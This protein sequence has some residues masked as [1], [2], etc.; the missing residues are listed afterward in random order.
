MSITKYNDIVKDICCVTF[1][2][3]QG[4]NMQAERRGQRPDHDLL[5]EM[6]G[7]IGVSC[8]LAFLQGISPTTNDMLAHFDMASYHFEMIDRPLKRL[9][10]NGV[11]A[12]A[13]DLRND[14]VLLGKDCLTADTRNEWC[15]IAG[16]S[17]GFCGLK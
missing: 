10:S 3:L 17:S 4:E 5:G 15:W 8:V 9:I 14:Q 16:I 13:R 11:F 2:R 6:D 1:E 7:W 12:P